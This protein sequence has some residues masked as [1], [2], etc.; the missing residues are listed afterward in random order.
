MKLIFIQGVQFP[1]YNVLHQLHTH[2]A[3]LNRK[4]P[5][6]K[7]KFEDRAIDL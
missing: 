4:A 6:F 3:T 1:V 2:F 5:N 7:G